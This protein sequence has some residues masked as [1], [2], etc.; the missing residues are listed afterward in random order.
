MIVFNYT[1]KMFGNIFPKDIDDWHKAYPDVNIELALAQM[2]QWLLA[3]KK[4][5]KKNYRKFIINWLS[6]NQ[7]EK[8][9]IMTLAAKPEKSKKCIVCK[10]PTREESQFCKSC[11]FAYDRLPEYV[12]YHG[13][14]I[15]KYKLPVAEIEKMILAERARRI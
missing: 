2:T 6:K 9:T 14:K 10:E 1:S 15:L 5:A 13:V 8:E 7:R 4:R 3:D 11:G 12:K